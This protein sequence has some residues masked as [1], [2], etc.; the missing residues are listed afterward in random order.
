ML[1]SRI[2]GEVHML[3]HL[4]GAANR[5]DIRR[6]RQLEEEKT[7]LEAKVARQQTHLGDTLSAR[8]RKIQDLTHALGKMMAE[9][10]ARDES[11]RVNGGAVS[12]DGAIVGVVA[13]LERR[14]TMEARRREH[15]ERRLVELSR[16]LAERDSRHAALARREQE[17]REELDTIEAALSPSAKGECGRDEV[18]DLQGLSL[19]YV[20]GR[21][22][23]TAHLRGLAE[24]HAA[25]FLHH[26]GGIEDRDGL[27]A[28]LIH[29]SDAVLFPVDCISHRAVAAV[30]RLCRQAGKPYVPLRSAGMTSMLAALRGPVLAALR[31]GTPA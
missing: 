19:L 12:D 15:A 18:I 24:R 23:A 14:L 25:T 2:F 29:R 21:A 11:G 3:S 7:A 30:K 22:S 31:P 13:E 16:R 8:D 17:L 1:M 6:L 28:G 27:L 9:R 5:A 20:G 4:V 26:D 10:E